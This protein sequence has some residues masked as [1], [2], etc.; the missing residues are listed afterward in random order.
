MKFEPQPIPDLV[1]VMP[2]VFDD[3]RGF[4]ME[5]WQAR[6]FAGAGIDATF[7][8]ANHAKSK[9]GVLRGLH[10]QLRQP[11]GKLVRVTAGEVFDVA[12]DLRRS[13]P[14]FGK[15]VGVY[16]SAENKH[17]FWMPPGFA[18][19]FYVT[20]DVAEFV[21]SC[22]DFYAPEDER[23]ILWSDPDLAIEWPV[24]EAPPPVVSDKD[25]TGTRFRDAECYP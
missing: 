16:L 25:A 20:S 14:T 18:H 2:E 13:G 22:T 4:F 1:L 3:D 23:C 6:E 15:W 11:Q 19:G 8:Q 9:K 5:T 24:N 21:Y 17:S 12:V 7:V 10:Y